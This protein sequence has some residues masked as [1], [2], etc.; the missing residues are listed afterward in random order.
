MLGTGITKRFALVSI[1][2]LLAI[3][4]LVSVSTLNFYLTMI[5]IFLVLPAF[6]CHVY[7]IFRFSL[8]KK[9][10]F[11]VWSIASMFFVF[12]CFEI[13]IVPLMVISPSENI[14]FYILFSAIISCVRRIQKNATQS[15]TKID[16]IY[17]RLQ[18]K[19][20]FIREKKPC[21]IC[22]VRKSDS[23]TLCNSCQI[24]ALR[25]NHYNAW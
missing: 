19:K 23:T 4:L 16:S 8:P 13:L 21:T 12:I 24:S 25:K 9:K 14:L 10:F 6:L 15:G 2:P 3:P 5:V 17:H 18:E 7:L 1:S 11:Y 22:C 20:P